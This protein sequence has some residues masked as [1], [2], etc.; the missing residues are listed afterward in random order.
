METYA[1]ALNIAIPVFI[2]LMLLE[3]AVSHMR[4]IEVSHLMD[5]V[6]SLSSGVTNI[7]KDVLG[8][9]ISIISYSW[10]AEHIS[11]FTLPVNVWTVVLSFI[12]LDFAQY[13]LH[14]ME[15]RVN[16]F[17]NRHIIHHSSEE[18]N[19]PCALR[20]PIS[21]VFSYYPF[22]LLPMA[23]LGVPAELFAIVAPVHLFLQF[24][25]HTRL[26]GKMGFLEKFLMTPSHHRVHHAINPEYLDKNYAPIFVLWDKWFGTFQEELEHVPP[27][28]G[29]KRPV[30]S[31][32]PLWI[33]FQ[34]FWL[35]LTD[36]VRTEK[37]L[38]KIRI[39]FMPTGWRPE[40]VKQKYPVK[41]WEN[42]YDQVKY[43]T[44]ASLLLKSW[45]AL[46]LVVT[47]SLALY[48]FN[49]I[50]DLQGVSMLIYGAFIFYSV[51]SYTSLMDGNRFAWLL[52]LVRSGGMLLWIWL[53]GDW[54][55]ASEWWEGLPVVIAAY[56]IISA[57]VVSWIYFSET[58]QPHQEEGLAV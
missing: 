4:G 3:L 35:I 21:D 58:V 28:Y 32:N 24:W 19:L 20:Q 17:W 41:V 23:L 42:V 36:A 10:L 18:Y 39:W 1:M 22:F 40:D 33:S 46:Q 30:S 13:W 12:G 9:G 50:S 45:S 14:R 2:V 16:I 51:F 53:S 52:E 54:F 25:Y 44:N 8:L 47:L 11:L 34:H 5:A 38:D 31:W 26:I 6:S 56:A 43:Q 57:V 7:T 37:L 15:H 27:V 55:R 48:L 29:V 49:R